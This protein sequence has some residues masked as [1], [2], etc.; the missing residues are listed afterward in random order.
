MPD[1]V[2]Q[3]KPRRH[4][5]SHWDHPVDEGRRQARAK[6]HRRRKIL[7]ITAAAITVF[8]VAAYLYLT[9]DSRIESYAESYLKDQLG[10]QVLLGR[11]SFSWTEGLVLEDLK[12]LSP[13]PFN[14]PIVTAERVRLKMRP[15]SLLKFSPEVT[16]VVVTRPQVNLVLWN[17]REWNFQALAKARPPGGGAAVTQRP[18]VVLQD[19][20]LWVKRKVAGV[21]MYEHPI[22]VSG[23]LAPDELNPDALRF[24]TQAE[25]SGVHL[26]VASGLIDA[27]TG[28][29]SF[30][31]HVSAD[32]GSRQDL[33]D[34]LPAEARSIWDRFHP[35][36]EVNLAILFDEKEGFRLA[37]DLANLAFTTSYKDQTYKFEHLTGRCGFSRKGLVLAGV[38]GTVNGTPVRLD[39]QVTGLQAER[40]GQAQPPPVQ[41]LGL[42]LVAQADRV[43]F[44]KNRDSFQALAPAVAELYRDYAP[45]GQVDVTM[46][47]KRQSGKD[48]PLEVSGAAYCRDVEFTYREFPYRIDGLHGSVQFDTTGFQ[49]SG[50]EGRHGQ[51]A[52]RIDGWAKDP[53][54][55]TTESLVRVHGGDV[56]LDED[57]RAALGPNE[58]KIYDQ[59][60]P[61]GAAD[62]DVEIYQPPQADAHSRM[63]VRLAL[64]GCRVKYEGFPYQLTG[65]TGRLNILPGRTEIAGVRGR[66]GEA[67]V[68]LDGEVLWK[69][70][71][72][73]AQVNLKIDGRDVALDEDLMAALQPRQREV[74][75]MYHLS[76]LA[77]VAGTVV[78]SA[79]T[80]YEPD[81]NLTIDLRSARM[82]Y[83]AF[84][85]AAERM[86]GRLRLAGGSCRI[87]SIVGSHGDAR[88]EATGWIDQRADDYAMD[89]TL[90]GQDVTLDEALRGALPSSVRSAWTH[91]APRGNVDIDARLTKALGAR[92][93]VT[94]R[95]K[96]T[97]RD[98]QARL[99]FF[100]YPLQHLTGLLDFEGSGV[101]LVG[102]KASDGT[103]EFGFDGTITYGPLGPEIDLA[104]KARGLR[105]D[106]PVRDAVPAPLKKALALIRP[107]GRVDLDIDHLTYKPTGPDT[108]EAAWS[109]KALLDEVGLEIGV[110]TEA[111]VGTAEM[112]GRWTDRDVEIHSRLHLQ[113]G[114]LADKILTDA[115]M[116]ID[117]AA[118]SSDLAI[119][120]IEGLFYG[121]RIEGSAAAGLGPAARYTLSLAADGVD[122]EK[123][124]HEGFRIEQDVSGGKVKATLNLAA[125]GTD[126][127][128][129]EASGYIDISDT[130]LYEL[131]LTMRVFNALRLASG[132]RTAF[133]SAR[134]LYFVSGR[135]I[136]LTDI[137]LDGPSISLYGAGSVE[138]DGKLNLTFLT[139][140]RDQDPLIPALSQ[141]AEG[142][143]KELVVVQVTGTLAEPKVEMQSL[144]GITAPLKELLSFILEHRGRQPPAKRP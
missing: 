142:I 129:V 17:D 135:R 33:Y 66:H 116:Q 102:L 110:K 118:D 2:T 28:A 83:E 59:F 27:R 85:Y 73:P 114:K 137:R 88:I 54:S 133:T 111:L 68:A 30:E 3:P 100:P 90:R 77:D 128:V 99:D 98:A 50:L 140:A 23:L 91:I 55:T 15:W 138:P 61:A 43:D 113:Q 79:E 144:S 141:L 24:Q 104:L 134:V 53:G 46:H 76:G 126:A 62:V 52:I 124:L 81:Y 32:L 108:A 132:D 14:E 106:G 44:Q 60:A 31:G 125:G 34:A 25:T 78:S 10:T 96:V 42:D 64:K 58:R 11:A 67:V 29:L 13:A 6:S 117:K 109:G 122:L 71:K 22:R 35:T 9:S 119:R 131:P 86:T 41:D 57:L 39:G 63:T 120:G 19:G 97:M 8:L 121:G 136:I 12:V 1:D 89:I 82:V 127:V 20:T 95:V 65:T 51:A 47:I 112:S 40:L 107:T 70:I 94:H 69:G 92:E 38:Q 4:R 87:D 84:P 37:A 130:R 21:T 48:T 123:I 49:T 36:G 139:G 143:R 74:L 18:V 5:P 16:E 103:T 105:L 56:P 7:L 101:R 45:R 80:G 93:Q 72:E 115:R 26:T 75:K